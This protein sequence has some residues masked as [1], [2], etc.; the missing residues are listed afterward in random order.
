MPIRSSIKQNDLPNM[1]DMEALKARE[2]YLE[3]R[4]EVIRQ[5][6]LDLSLYGPDEPG[7][8]EDS[9]NAA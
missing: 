2:K 3:D 1:N 7:E 8:S 9:D 4:L 6:I 5:R